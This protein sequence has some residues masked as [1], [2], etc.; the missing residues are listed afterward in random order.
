MFDRLKAN[1]GNDQRF[2]FLNVAVSDRAGKLPFFYLAE[3][4][5]AELPNLPLGTTG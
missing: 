3:T 2:V 5:K 4:A 1:Y